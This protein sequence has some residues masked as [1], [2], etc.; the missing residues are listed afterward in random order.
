VIAALSCLGK[1][2]GFERISLFFLRE[3]NGI[4]K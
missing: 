2:M 1:R 3:E 4:S